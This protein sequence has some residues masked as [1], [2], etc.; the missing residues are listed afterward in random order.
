MTDYSTA[1]LRG[2]LLRSLASPIS[3]ILQ[4]VSRPVLASGSRHEHITT[5]M[6]PHLFR[7]EGFAED[8]FDSYPSH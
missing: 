6:Q 2:L 1:T 8:L 4:A 5:G 3:S 7:S